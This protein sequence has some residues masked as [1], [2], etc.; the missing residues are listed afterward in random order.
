MKTVRSKKQISPT[1]KD[2]RKENPHL[3]DYMKNPRLKTFAKPV[4]QYSLSRPG[5]WEKSL[6]PS[7]PNTLLEGV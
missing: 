7:A 1:K 6:N 2:Q 3:L 5:P 4:N